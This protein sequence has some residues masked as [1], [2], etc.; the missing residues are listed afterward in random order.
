[1]VDSKNGGKDVSLPG[2]FVFVIRGS[3]DLQSRDSEQFGV[4]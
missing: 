4:K 2:S 1:M 3:R